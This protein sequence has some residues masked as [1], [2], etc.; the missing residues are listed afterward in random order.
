MYMHTVN[1]NIPQCATQCS[2]MW[3]SSEQRLFGPVSNVARGSTSLHSSINIPP[4]CCTTWLPV[5]LTCHQLLSVAA[6]ANFTGGSTCTEL[7][8]LPKLRTKL[9]F[10]KG[11]KVAL[12]GRVP[13]LHQPSP[14]LP[15]RKWVTPMVCAE[16][17]P[18]VTH[19]DCSTPPCEPLHNFITTVA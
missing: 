5:P 14:S 4:L 2:C 8:K 11:S 16:S 15:I 3:N 17:F 19:A 12:L 1:L 6:E 18:K 9:C 10:K 13:G 7:C